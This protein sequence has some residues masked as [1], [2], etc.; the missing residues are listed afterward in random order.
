MSRFFKKQNTVDHYDWVSHGP[1]YEWLL[2]TLKKYKYLRITSN[3]LR[4]TASD[5]WLLRGLTAHVV[6]RESISAK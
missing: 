1:G 6:E 5:Y 4:M 2:V 3:W